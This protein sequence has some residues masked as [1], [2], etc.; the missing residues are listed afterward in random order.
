MLLLERYVESVQA[1]AAGA[2]P[3]RPVNPGAGS[4]HD[5]RHS[6]STSP[7]PPTP[8]PSARPGEAHLITPDRYR[9]STEV[10][11]T[12][13][14]PLNSEHPESGGLSKKAAL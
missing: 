2:A 6:A 11:T 10:G 3:L 7:A 5:E 14:T 13:H 9:S 12:S 8:N 1:E 4:A